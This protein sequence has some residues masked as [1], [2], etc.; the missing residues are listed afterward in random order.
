M[1]GFLQRFYEKKK[2]LGTSDAWSMSRS[3]QRP[4]YYIEYCQILCNILGILR[5]SKKYNSFCLECCHP[6]FKTIQKNNLTGLG[7]WLLIA[8]IYHLPSFKYQSQKRLDSLSLGLEFNLDLL[9]LHIGAKVFKFA[10][11]LPDKRSF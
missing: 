7:L 8:I 2:I 3:S 9:G 1:K 6:S 10:I 11:R 4:A 5:R